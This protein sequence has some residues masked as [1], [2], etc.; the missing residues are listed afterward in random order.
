M[1]KVEVGLMIMLF[2]IVIN[3]F[4][5][6]NV[7]A[8]GNPYKEKG[9]Y[10]TNCTWYAWKMA[11]EKAGVT[12]PGWGNAKNWYHDAKESGYTVGTTPKANSIIVW[13][14]W[15]SYGHVG[16]VEKVENGVLSV[17]DSTGP[18]IDREDPEYVECIMNGVS[19]E[20][21]K[22]CN[23]NAKKIAC[24][25]TTSP[26]LYGITGYI[27][28]DDA[29]KKP[30]PTPSATPKPT[31][32]PSS[33]TNAKP[34][35]ENSSTNL[36]VVKSSNANLSD[37]VLSNGIIQ[38]NKEVLE[39]SVEVEYEVHEITINATLEDK[40]AK[41]E[42][43]GDYKLNV[44]FNE[45]KLIVTAEDNSTKEYVIKI[46]R[47]EEAKVELDSDIENNQTEDSIPKNDDLQKIKL[48][49]VIC[50]LILVGVCFL[51]FLKRKKHHK[52]VKGRK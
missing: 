52:N 40:K 35:K 47:S 24:E 41:V 32:S 43:T 21:D 11:S 45:I 13:G 8:A 50:F 18:C 9:P 25:Y 36:E 14:G 10:G 48:I 51:F 1:K 27:Y 30:A 39:Y 42:G 44:G 20:T 26:D 12:L 5:M 3:T 46:T 37:I 16:Y 15:T 38:F 22:I 4:G 2:L 17:W 28:L 23:Q 31:P 7:S 29:P 19:E 6:L 49:S 34:N 33:N